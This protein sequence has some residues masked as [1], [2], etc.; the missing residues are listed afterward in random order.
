M[1]GAIRPAARRLT[2][3]SAAFAL[4]DIIVGC[5]IFGIASLAILAGFG[6]GWIGLSTEYAA[7]AMTFGSV[8]Q[9]RS[10][11]G[12]LV[13]CPLLALVVAWLGYRSFNLPRRLWKLA[14]AR[15]SE[16]RTGA[17]GPSPAPN[18]SRPFVPMAD[19]ALWA[20]RL[21]RAPEE[22]RYLSLLIGA[23]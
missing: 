1:P 19:A 5:T 11:A 23:P 10:A 22:Y 6:L 7:H 16:A 9:L 18:G 15:S 20:V 12:L 4:A 13:V 21:R 8:A 14:L 17:P 2:L 3:A